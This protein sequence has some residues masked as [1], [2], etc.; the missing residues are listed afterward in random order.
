MTLAELSELLRDGENSGVEFKRDDIQPQDLAKELVALSNL[1]GGRILLGV[2]DDGTISG[3]VRDAVDEWVLTIA[4]DKVRLP[5][6]PH[7]QTVTDPGSGRRVSVVTVEAGYAVH[8]VWHHNHFSYYIRVGRQSREASPEEL[9]RLQQ[10]RG[11]FRAE[12]RPISGAS[13][14]D[15]DQRRLEDYFRRVRGQDVPDQQ[16]RA[17]WVQLL[18]ATEFL[19]EGISEPVPCLAAIALFGR[20]TGRYLPQSG[21][22]A[23]AYPSVEKDYAAIER[24]TLRGPLAPL[25]TRLGELVEPGLVDSAVA[26]VRRNVG[27]RAELVDGVRRVEIPGLPAEPVREALVNAVIH[28][29]YLLA[30]TDVE[31]GLYPDRLEIVSPGRLPNGVTVERM[32]A[33]TRAA[34]N[35]LLK[36][37]MRDYGYLEHMGLGVPRKIVRGMREFNGSQ[38]EFVVGQESLAVVLRR[39]P[40]QRR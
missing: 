22:D 30:H 12:L 16:D 26:F 23:V 40:G 14:E 2:E 20:A 13:Y 3:V 4:R 37:V 8:A 38:P 29:D 5:L 36:D 6:I 34:R 35:E 1:R 39:V 31:L 18:S 15:L 24:A 33:G 19:V 28:R 27:V 21:I 9:S 17:G 7:V 25:M 11:G 32:L 10:Q